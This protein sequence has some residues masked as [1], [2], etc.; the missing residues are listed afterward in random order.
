MQEI[1]REV[2]AKK[3]LEKS[4]LK[5]ELEKNILRYFSG[6]CYGKV[7]NNKPG[8]TYMEWILLSSITNA[9]WFSHS[10]VP[11]SSL[12]ATVVDKDT[13][14]R[15]KSSWN[16]ECMANR[17]LKREPKMNEPASGQTNERRRLILFSHP[18]IFLSFLEMSFIT[19]EFPSF[20]SSPLQLKIS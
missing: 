11:S 15:K 19:L 14:S 13:A 8:E 4:K 20:S 16:V 10:T 18:E 9:F 17:E 12:A 1:K 3:Q 2:A 5:N 7:N 6:R